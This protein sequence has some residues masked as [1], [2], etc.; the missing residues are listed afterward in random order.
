MFDKYIKIYF[1]YI[2]II[3]IKYMDS[4]LMNWVNQRMCLNRVVKEWNQGFRGLE[5]G[6]EEKSKGRESASEILHDSNGSGK[7]PK[8][9]NDSGKKSHCNRII[10]GI[11]G[12]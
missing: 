5:N 11:N 9:G 1:I 4:I 7:I 2:G 12:G 6:T 3:F 10:I 8:Q